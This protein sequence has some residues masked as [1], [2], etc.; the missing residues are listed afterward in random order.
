[1]VNNLD[2]GADAVEHYLEIQ[3]LVVDKSE[4]SHSTPKEE[5]ITLPRQLKF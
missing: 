1:M 3:D 2:L 4:H 5:A